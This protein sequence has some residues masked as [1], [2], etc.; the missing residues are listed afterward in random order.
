MRRIT[1]RMLL[2]KM[3]DL[4]SYSDHLRLNPK[5]IAAL[6]EDILINVTSFFRDPETFE[7]LKTDIFPKIFK[8]S[9][10]RSS[11]NLGSWMFHRRGTLFNRNC[12]VEYLGEQS[13]GARKSKFLQQI[14]ARLRLKKL[15]RGIFSYDIIN[16]VRTDRLRRFFVKTEH[17]YQVHK[18][19]R[20]MCVFAKHNVAKDP[21]F[22][23]LD[24]ISCRNLLIYFGP[25]LQKKIIPVFHYALNANGYLLLGD[26]ESIGGFGDYFYPGDKK[27]KIFLKKPMPTRI[28][29]EPDH[30]S[31]APAM[32]KL[33]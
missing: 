27:F 6:Y 20:D 32:A 9:G 24:L 30:F 21:P 25:H 16:D 33:Q 19:I 14:L 11:P 5:E 26:T 8:K 29:Y 15:A 13:A 17:G 22:S 1:R 3:D 23:R 28:H 10:P 12:T 18:M 2:Q 7:I 4:K 31:R